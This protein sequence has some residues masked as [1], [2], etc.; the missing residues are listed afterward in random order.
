MPRSKGYTHAR[1]THP[2][3]LVRKTAGCVRDRCGQCLQDGA[4]AAETAPERGAA[5]TYSGGFQPQP[6]PYALSFRPPLIAAQW[7]HIGTFVLGVV[8]L[9][10][11]FAP[12]SKEEGADSEGYSAY[13]GGAGL[14]PALSF[15]AGTVALLAN[16]YPLRR[17]YRG[18]TRPGP[19]ADHPARHHARQHPERAGR[20][21]PGHDPAIHT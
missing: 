18:Q 6:Q 8:L 3:R 21:R 13:E 2:L 16:L 10:L 17:T 4:S 1:A 15:A 20:R 12:W 9:F 7:L 11:G 5:M 14:S 19:A